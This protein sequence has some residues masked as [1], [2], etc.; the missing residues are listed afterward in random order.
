METMLKIEHSNNA[1]ALLWKSS[2]IW[3]INIFFRKFY[4]RFLMLSVFK[5]ELIIFIWE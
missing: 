5:T 1:Y 3:L 4:R 2:K